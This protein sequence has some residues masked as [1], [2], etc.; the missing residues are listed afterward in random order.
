MSLR[1]KATATL[2]VGALLSFYAAAQAD[3]PVA[4]GLK[5]ATEVTVREALQ[6]L[7]PDGFETLRHVE[8]RHGRTLS[9]ADAFELMQTEQF[10][11]KQHGFQ[12][13]FCQQPRH[14]RVIA[15]QPSL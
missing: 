15:C 8:F 13:E 14:A 3:A 5:T 12:R 6:A 1:L 7:T 10:E 4:A 9:N 11:L 2:L